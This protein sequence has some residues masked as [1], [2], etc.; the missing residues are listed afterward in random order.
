MILVLS[1]VRLFILGVCPTK[2]ENI[3]LAAKSYSKS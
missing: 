2:Q 3:Y 1:G